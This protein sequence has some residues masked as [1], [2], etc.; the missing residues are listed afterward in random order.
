MKPLNKSDKYEELYQSLGNTKDS[1]FNSMKDV[2]VLAAL[3]GAIKENKKKFNKK[4][5]EPIKEG[6]FNYS[7][8]VILDFIAVNATKDINIL[9]ND[10]EELN[11]KSNLL[12]EYAN[13]GMETLEKYL[14]EDP[15]NIDR[16]I[17]CVKEIDMEL[18]EFIK[19]STEDLLIGLAL[20][21]DSL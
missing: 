15:L 11:S 8:K 4:G 12:E 14:A 19:P 2:Y 16:L 10:E 3:L 17:Q 18:N 1:L 9:K 6:I 13:G 21:I 7:D 20:E 5:G